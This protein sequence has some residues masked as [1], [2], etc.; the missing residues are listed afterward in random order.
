MTFKKSLDVSF[1]YFLT[2]VTGKVN[3]Q[4]CVM[5]YFRR[6]TPRELPWAFE[7]PW[8]YVWNPSKPRTSDHV[9][10]ACNCVR[11]YYAGV[12][13][14]FYL[15]LSLSLFSPAFSLLCRL[16]GCLSRVLDEDFYKQPF[17]ELIGYV[18]VAPTNIFPSSSS[19]LISFPPLPSTPSSPTTD[20]TFTSFVYVPVLLCSH[21]IF[22]FPFLTVCISDCLRHLLAC[23]C[24]FQF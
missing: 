4:S 20:V 9:A 11:T 8:H 3:H 21:A 13:V 17:S 19:F 12:S 10:W 6:Q 2:D 15:L 5:K 23:R 14:L 18:Y 24:V 22:P 7:T 1:S 16:G